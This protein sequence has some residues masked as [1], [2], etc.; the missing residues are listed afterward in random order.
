[1]SVNLTNF[2]NF[3]CKNR[4]G[5]GNL[6]KVIFQNNL[7]EDFHMK[8]MRTILGATL[9]MLLASGLFANNIVVENISMTGQDAG[10]NYTMIEFD[11][12]W[13]NSWQVS[14]A[15]SNWD[16]AWV[17]A[18][19]QD[20]GGAWSHCTLNTTDGNHTAP[21]GSTIDAASDGTGV[22]IYRS[23]D[24]NGSNNWD[25]T[26]L[27]WQYG[28]DGV[29]DDASVTVKVFAIEMVYVPQASFKLG[30]GGTETSAFYQYPTT[31]NTYTISNENA[32]T[33]G[34]TEGNLYYPSS[35]YGG[36]RAGP[37][38]AAFP[39]GYDAFYCMKYEISQEQ[40]AEFLNKLTYNQQATRTANA[41]SSAAGTG[42]LI[43]GNSNRC[44][45]DIMT[46]GVAGTTPA[47]YACNLDG[48]GTYNETVDGQNIACNY[49]SWADLAAYLD[50][51]A[52]R[53][54]SELEFEK[55]CRGTVT[56]VANEYAWGTTDI[57]GSAY[58]LSN[59]G[60]A[61]EG[62]ANNYSTSAGNASYRT[63]V[64]SINGPLRCG[65]FAANGSNTG[66]ETAG[67]T[68][69]GIMEMSGNLWERPVTVGNATG[70]AFTGI[71]GD[72]VLNATTGNAN[73]TNW[74]NTTATGAGLRGGFLTTY[75]I[76]LRVSD[77]YYAAVTSSVRGTSYG[78]RGVRLGP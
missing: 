72:G 32:I 4:G 10:N 43:T 27:R 31:T 7:G 46:S 12:A 58:T 30:S 17:F 22:F 16:A 42:A 49:L 69:Y 50:W 74:P 52:L 63:T 6:L 60:A 3:P 11:I 35:T 39:K 56:P 70:R 21:S 5:G 76:Y 65:I 19:W 45:I 54:M 66:R 62:I 75:A 1:M 59:A 48:D 44:G 15:P 67:A 23:G 57:A 24:G 64:L 28:T 77:R 47:V 40:Y 26:Q 34:T 25:N 78:G 18:K 38:P 29:A 51:A 68:Y 55:A 41:P 71:N 61:N 9:I 73:S 36:D 33:V 20:N 13:D 37:I 53:P 2:F 8:K 14:S